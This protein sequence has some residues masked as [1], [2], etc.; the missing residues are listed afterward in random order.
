MSSRLLVP[1]LAVTILVVSGSILLF[2]MGSG[3]LETDSAGKTVQLDFVLIKCVNPVSVE[4]A[5]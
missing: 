4:N 5:R 1:V 3:R 2:Y